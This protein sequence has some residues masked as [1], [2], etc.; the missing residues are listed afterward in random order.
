MVKHLAIQSAPLIAQKLEQWLT[1]ITTTNFSG[2]LLSSWDSFN[3]FLSVLL[4]NS[5]DNTE[6]ASKFLVRLLQFDCQGPKL[7][8]L[9]LKS[10]GILYPRAATVNSN[11]LIAVVE[12]CF[13]YAE[14]TGGEK[15][16]SEFM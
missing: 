15:M 9:Y 14:F 4:A 5:S 3:H 16:V 10:L 8:L 12:E 1:E 7:L 13:Y 2:D 6:I 11:C